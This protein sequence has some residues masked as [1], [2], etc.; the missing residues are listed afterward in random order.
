M[1]KYD[2]MSRGELAR[3]ARED[4]PGLASEKQATQVVWSLA[5]DFARLLL[6]Q[7]VTADIE[8]D[9][10][11]DVR[12]VERSAVVQRAEGRSEA[13][14]ARIAIIQT[15]SDSLMVQLRDMTRL[16]TQTF[17]LGNEDI[18]YADSTPEQNEAYADREEARIAGALQ[19][20][21]LHR[22]VASFI[23]GRG[24][25]TLGEAVSGVAVTA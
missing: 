24:A 1:S 14:A 11:S 3:A 6:I 9:K 10:R 2:V 12:V 5:P 23:R 8:A 20:I 13:R 18:L 4:F 16:L 7:Y 21:A 22:E 15:A 25:R 17:R 19:T